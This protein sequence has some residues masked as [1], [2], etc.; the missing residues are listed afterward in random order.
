MHCAQCRTAKTVPFGTPRAQAKPEK[1][2]HLIVFAES[3][4]KEYSFDCTRLCITFDQTGTDPRPLK[5]APAGS[6]SRDARRVTLLDP[7]GQA[8]EN[9]AY[10]KE[11]T[12][13][14]ASRP[15][16]L[17]YTSNTPEEMFTT[18]ITG[19]EDMVACNNAES[20]QHGRP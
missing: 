10:L 4:A 18:V 5:V 15:G 6:C 1:S 12:E 3:V 16:W 8:G 13:T 14:Q 19:A 11:K 20:I 17:C 9:L 7:G 2:Q